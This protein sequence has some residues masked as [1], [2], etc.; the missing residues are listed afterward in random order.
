MKLSLFQLFVGISA[1]APHA[2]AWIEIAP[3]EPVVP[4][5]RDVAPHAGAWIEM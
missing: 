5:E 2:G 3:A 4:E 1:V